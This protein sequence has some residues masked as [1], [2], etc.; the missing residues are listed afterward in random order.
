MQGSFQPASIQ[1]YNASLPYEYEDRTIVNSTSSIDAFNQLTTSDDQMDILLV[2]V[3]IISFLCLS[4][5]SS[6]VE[7]SCNYFF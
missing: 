1:E 7:L 6:I 2:E 4:M 5:F 3:H